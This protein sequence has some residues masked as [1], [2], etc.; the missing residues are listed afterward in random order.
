[1]E[2]LFV[3]IHLNKLDNFI[4][5]I[6]FIKDKIFKIIVKYDL[7]YIK[8]MEDTV[9]NNNKI[10]NNSNRLINEKSPYL[11]QHAYNP[12]NWYP[13]GDEA[14]NRAA[15]EDKPI[16]LSIG[17]STCHWCH[18][19]ENESFTDHEIAK[20]MN[21][22]FI[23]IKVDREERPDLDR[24]YISAVTALTGSAG[25]PLNVFLTPKLKPFFGGTYFPA[26]SNFGITSWPDLLNRITSVW[27]DPV[28]HKDIISS[29][30]KIT[31][32]IIKNLSYDKVFST[33]EKH[34]QS[35]LDDAFKYYS[36][37]YD[38]K[39]AGF[40]KAPK[41]PSPSIIKFILA[42]FSYAKK[43]NEPAVAKRT[44]DMAD[45]TLKAMA[46]GGIYDQLRGG[47]HRYST[48]E[49]WHIPHFE[50]MLYDNAQLVNVYLEAYQIT[51][52][53]FF[54]QI[55]KETCDYILS[56]M[57]SS[58]G[59]FYSAE[60]ADSYPGQISEKGSDDAHNKVEGA[61]YV[62]SKKELDKILEENTAEIFSYFF[63]VMEEG[64]AAH[65]PH[66][67]FKK[68]N[69]LYVKH[70][71]NE[72]AKKYNMAPDKVELI[73]NDAKNKLL[74][75]RSSRERPHLDDKILTSWNGLMISAFAKAYKVLGSDKYLQAAKNAAEFIISNLYDKNTGKLFRRWR[76]GERAVLGMGSDYAF[77]I[78]GLIDLYESDSD[79]KWLETAVMLS[80]EYIKLFYDEQFAGFYITSPD[81][82]KNLI[83]RAKDDSDS[84]IPAHGSVAIQNLLRLSKITGRLYFDEIANKAIDAALSTSAFHPA[85]FPYMLAVIC[86]TQMKGAEV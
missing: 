43:I 15:K 58:P 56:D 28:V 46:K 41:F 53:K 60:D 35:H 54:A 61:F 26:E 40:G 23:C 2:R 72:A 18:V 83:I 52:D 31:D 12:V 57:T 75:A 71:I 24:I 25:W 62:W 45:Y 42:Y 86:D 81:H 17:Y 63:G 33:A 13:W 70:S 78:C 69:I 49:K 19:M 68:K 85:L 16:I 8:I 55:A 7:V 38:E 74:K 79:K 59:G 47:F 6:I 66:G 37:S 14:I 80:E 20:I 44:I 30:E 76:E 73:I 77:Y 29:S 67:Y 21:D 10:R 1:M 36:S 5:G 48:D 3:I 64:N 65:D 4:L 51:S 32:I 39:Y 84:V 11:L 82:D 27:K 34:K 22:N 50:K 9:L